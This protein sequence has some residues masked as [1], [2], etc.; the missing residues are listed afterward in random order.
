MQGSLH[1][2]KL[3][4]LERFSIECRKTNAKV[5]TSTNQSTVDANSAMNQSK[6]VKIPCNLLKAREKSRLQVAIDF[7]F[8]FQWLSVESNQRIALVLHY[9][10]Q[11]LVQSSRAI[12]STNHK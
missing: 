4:N 9:F 6:F 11:R 3:G 5:I 1:I 12:F 8:P 2:G 10:T 7:D